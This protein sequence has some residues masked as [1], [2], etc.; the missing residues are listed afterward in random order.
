MTETSRAAGRPAA[1]VPM[2]QEN[3]SRTAPL[4][5]SEIFLQIRTTTYIPV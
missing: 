2:R 3:I 4:C 1:S 5:V